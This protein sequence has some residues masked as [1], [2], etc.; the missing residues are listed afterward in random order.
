[1]QIIL[2]ERRAHLLF[3]ILALT[4]DQILRLST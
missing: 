4:A 1:M 3:G 2:L